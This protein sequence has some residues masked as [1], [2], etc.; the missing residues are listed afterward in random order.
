ML[1]IVAY[2]DVPIYVN[3]WV[4]LQLIKWLRDGQWC[5]LVLSFFLLAR[6]THE[7]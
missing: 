5:L 4:F 2:F 7:V 6:S 3:A 1:L